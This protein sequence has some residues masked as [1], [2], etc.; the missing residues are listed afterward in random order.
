[1]F[2][3]HAAAF[4]QGGGISAMITTRVR[5]AETLPE[6]ED[7]LNEWGSNFTATNTA[8]A[9]TRAGNLAHKQPA[10]AMR[11]VNRLAGVWDSVLPDAEPRQLANVL[12]ASGKLQ[13][14]NAELWSSTLAGF[15]Q[16]LQQGKSEKACFDIATVAHGL[17]NVAIANKGEVP[18]VDRS[19]VTAAFCEMMERMRLLVTAPLLEGVNPQDISNTLW[20]CAKLRINPGDVAVDSLVRAMSRPAMLEKAVPQ[21]ISNTLWAASQ[22]R[23]ECSWQPKLDQRVWQRLLAEDQLPRVADRGKP[24]Q[25][26]NVLLALQWLSSPA[27]GGGPA[28]DREFARQCAA[29]LQSGTPAGSVGAAKRIQQHVGLLTA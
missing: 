29:A 16:Q 27:A 13:Y 4:E 2:V 19:E 9:L 3:C 24:N 17:A 15:M 18:G 21:N 8:A 7:I 1:L 26:S 22:L 28:L 14:S 12:W 10:V 5:D 23:Q 6:L 25:L 11:L 20:A